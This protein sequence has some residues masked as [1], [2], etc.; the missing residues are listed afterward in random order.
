MQGVSQTQTAWAGH[1]EI[2]HPWSMEIWPCM[3]VQACNI[4]DTCMQGWSMFLIAYAA[5]MPKLILYT[6]AS[7]DGFFY[8]LVLVDPHKICM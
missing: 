6:L 1:D 4:L 3:Q 8:V 5:E 7:R 2:M